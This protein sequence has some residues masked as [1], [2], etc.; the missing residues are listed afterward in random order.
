M[1]PNPETYRFTVRG[2]P[3]GEGAPPFREGA[4][5]HAEGNGRRRGENR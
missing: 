4:H 5:L 1:A 3:P 2:A